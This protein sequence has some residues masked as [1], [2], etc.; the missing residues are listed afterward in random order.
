MSVQNSI[1]QFFT[2]AKYSLFSKPSAVCL[3][4]AAFCLFMFGTF[5]R[6][7]FGR[8]TRNFNPASD[9][10]TVTQHHYRKRSD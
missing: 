7:Y 6:S 2:V 10:Y 1:S 4:P 5:W 9:D 8:S 3:L